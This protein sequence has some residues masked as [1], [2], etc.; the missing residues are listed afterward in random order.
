MKYIRKAD[1]RG[2]VDFGWLQS[3]HSFSFGNYYDPKH[4]GVS[5]LRVINDDVV[6]PS[7][8][9]GTHG[10]S[11]MEI[12]S[13]V[14]EGSLKHED[15]GGNKFVV[16]AGEVQR[17]SAGSGITHS[18][19][20][21]SNTENVRFLQIWIQPK[22]KGI[23]PSYEQKKIEQNGPLTA[24]ATPDGEDGSLSMNQDASI[25]RLRLS[26]NQSF[27]L[28]T[29]ER[30]GYLHIISGD[31]KINETKFAPGDAFSLEEN[32]SVTIVAEAD[33]EALWFDL[34]VEQ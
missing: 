26:A 24:L 9:F 19:F 30:V 2:R 20:N 3:N 5:V 25:Y 22:L 14:I 10:H 34:P 16:P 28:N 11:N 32:Q 13:Y 4:M 15:S 18:E 12:V 6:M 23:D 21:P 31:I 1:E 7:Q 29:E 8:G 17:I 27:E 33:F